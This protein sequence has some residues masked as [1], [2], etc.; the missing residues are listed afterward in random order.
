MSLILKH[1]TVVDWETLAFRSGHLKV[2]E[3]LNG[4]VTFLPENTDP[5][6]AEIG[7][8]SHPS[9]PVIDCTHKLVTKS[10]AC[11][12]HHAYS[13]LSRGMGAPKIA[14]T[15][16]EDILKSIW[17]KLDKC[18]D[19]EMIRAS[20][21]VTALFCAKNG[22]TFVI[23]HHASPLAVE[24]SLETIAH[25]FDQVGISHLLCVECSDRD[26]EAARQKGLD[27]TER[28]LLRGGQGLVGLHASFTVGRELLAAA[29][30]LA[31]TYKTG[32]HVHVAEDR[33]D[34]DHCLRDYGRR[35]IE[36]FRD[37]GGL[38]SEKTILAHC[39]HLDAKEREILGRSPVY[40]AQN[41]ESNLNNRVG[42]FNSR[43]LDEAHILLGTDG[44]HSDMLRSAKA[45][46]LAGQCRENLSAEQM[47]R[48]FRNV[49]HYIRESGWTGDGDNNLV[50]LD[51]DSPTEIRSDNFFGHFIYGIE[52]SDVESVIS[53]GRLIV[54]ERK[55][56]TVD[57]AEIF[58]FSKEM[59]NK[60]HR[61]FR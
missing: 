18:L 6:E 5:L 16:F 51:Y 8:S 3:G 44:M 61:C 37:A 29:V 56:Q 28:F 23:D 1:A 9:Q 46:F 19:T 2:E 20:A 21:L 14:P 53:N 17:W 55:V 48:R 45:A 49:H 32:L 39:L 52:S 12:H 57:E 47:Y 50:I 24:H 41:T 54:H 4:G 25:A 26:G 31:R 59:A 60:L 34:Q 33:V 35:V 15:C 42:N 11:G 38:D 36:R 30:A 58:K 43:S 40:I 10:F 13:A 7:S 22:V 27:E